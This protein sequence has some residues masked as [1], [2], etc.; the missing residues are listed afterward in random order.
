[1][2]QDLRPGLLNLN[3][4]IDEEVFFS[5]VSESGLG[6]YLASWGVT[7]NTRL[8]TA[9]INGYSPGNL[10]STPLNPV[11]P[12]TIL[13]NPMFTG[14]VNANQRRF[15]VGSV[16]SAGPTATVNQPQNRLGQ[17]PVIV[18]QVNIAGTPTAFYPMPNVGFFDTDPTQAANPNAVAGTVNNILP[19]NPNNLMKGAFSDFLKLR[20]GGS[21]FMFSYGGGNTGD[22]ILYA[23]PNSNQTTAIASERPF[24]ALSYPDINYTVMRPASLPPSPSTYYP[25]FPAGQPSSVG[26]TNSGWTVTNPGTATV[27]GPYQQPADPNRGPTRDSESLVLTSPTGRPHG[28]GPEEPVLLHPAGDFRSDAATSPCPATAAGPP[29]PIP[30][31]RLFAIP[32]V[33]GS[34]NASDA[35]DVKVNQQTPLELNI[36][37]APMTNVTVNL[38]YNNEGDLALPDVSAASGNFPNA[39]APVNF[40]LGGNFGLTG[41]SNDRRQHP[42]FRTEW[43]QKMMNLTTVRTHQFAVWITVGFFE[44]TK[45]GD[46]LMVNDP[47]FYSLAYD[48]LGMELNVLSGRNIRYRSF[49]IVDR[50]KAVGFN[51]GAPGDFRNT[52]IYRQTIE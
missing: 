2:R 46:P 25:W 36:T 23:N 11:T 26:L 21:G 48:Q 34:S 44:V 10:L 1:M 5:L 29:P 27:T 40:A 31:Q 50:T 17:T 9:Q 42:Y 43:L 38:L 16:P 49:F 18:T 52:V 14:T 45:Q 32:D 51:P 4:I 13:I 8:N 3:L 19:N 30:A 7:G 20:H 47:N 41:T 24:H 6:Y 12:G 28:P 39:T 22:P 37:T 15:A 33:R 35:G